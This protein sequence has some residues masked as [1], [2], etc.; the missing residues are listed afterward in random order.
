MGAVVLSDVQE[1]SVM[2][3]NPAKFI[4]NNDNRRVFTK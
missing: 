2:V 4:R 1:N 3:G